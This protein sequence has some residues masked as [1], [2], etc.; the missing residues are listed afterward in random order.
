MCEPEQVDG[1]KGLTDCQGG[2]AMLFPQVA[3]I[4]LIYSTG[5]TREYPLQG[6]SDTRKSNSD[7]NLAPFSTIGTGYFSFGHLSAL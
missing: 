2:I 5:A 3:N 7:C 4:C 6:Q 1:K